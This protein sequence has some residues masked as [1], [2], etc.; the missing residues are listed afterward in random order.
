[1]A[2]YGKILRRGLPRTLGGP[3]WPP[4]DGAS[5][6][7]EAP[8]VES[9]RVADPIAVPEAASA[10]PAPAEGAAA[11]AG[12]ATGVAP[13]M[14][15]GLPRVPGG[16]PWPRDRAASVPAAQTSSP[17][18][19]AG[20]AAGTDT[21]A[22][23]SVAERDAASFDAMRVEANPI[24]RGLPRVPGGAAWPPG[25]MM[26][27]TILNPDVTP[28]G[29]GAAE[30]TAPAAL[31][32]PVRVT[33]PTIQRAPQLASA[34]QMRPTDPDPVPGPRKYGRFTAGQWIGAV[35]I[36]GAGLL[37]AVAVAVFLARWF[38]SLEFMRDFLVTYPGEYALPEDAPVGFPG[39]LAWQHFLNVFLM[40]LIIR[41]GIIIRREKRPTAYWTPKW[42][43]DSKEGKVS[44]TT[45][46]HQ[47]LDVLW[48]LNGAVFIL[49]LFVTGQWTRIVPTSWAVFP[50][51][52]SAALQY[53]SLHWPTEDGWT[54]YNS[55]QQLAYFT[56]VFLAAPLAAATGIRMS[57][58]WPKRATTLSKIY[59]IK[60]ARA[61][62]F[63]VMIYFVVFIILH[64]ALVL[65]TGALRNLN[66]IYGGQD[67]LNWT[68]FWIFFASLVVIVAGWIAA[69]PLLIAPIASLM[70]KVGR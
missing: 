21:A 45:W 37:C 15:R 12:T 6:L 46:F 55:L 13:R 3:P 36:T 52:L 41:T 48:L 22:A 68:G 62:H 23:A 30:T 65:A 29:P 64:I 9:I 39:W 57:A 49:L 19:A 35:I 27:R 18:A 26:N 25:R 63:P 10:A 17:A 16:E 44:L 5:I 43:K 69:R 24:R 33:A 4:A 42:S 11:A 56:T 61:I 53:M 54:N 51:A 59:S 20:T 32:D 2:T 70:G 58:I 8:A 28:S 14:R 38:L 1:M 31:A 60:A 7:D 47:A 50:N 40:V 67:A 66:H 34:P